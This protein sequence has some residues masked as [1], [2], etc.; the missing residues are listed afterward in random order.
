MDQ[1]AIEPDTDNDA[2]SAWLDAHDEPCPV[3]RYN[4]RGVRSPACPECN[5]PLTLG[6]RSPR[7]IFGPWAVALIACSLGL[8]FD[9]VTSLFMLAPV[10]GTGGEDPLAIAMWTTLTTL[11]VCSGIGVAWLLTRRRIWMRMR[12]GAQWRTAWTVFFGVGLLHLLAGGGL[13]AI[14]LMI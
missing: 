14:L 3:C 5:T 10:I 12:P 11:G 9:G 1:P 13:I 6:V 8:G 4:L 7:A 2:L